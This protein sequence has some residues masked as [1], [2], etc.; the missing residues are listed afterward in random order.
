MLLTYSI[1]VAVIVRIFLSA[2]SSIMST[3]YL[4]PVAGINLPSLAKY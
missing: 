1:Y 2:A 3:G 4:I